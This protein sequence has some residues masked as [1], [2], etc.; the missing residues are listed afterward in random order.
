[1][2]RPGPRRE[3]R[4]LGKQSPR[5]R[6]FLNP[7]THA[8]FTTCPQCGA[9]MRL[10][11]LPLVIH[12]D[13]Q[14]LVAL[15]KACRYCPGCDLLIAHQDEIERLLAGFLHDARPEIVG[16]RYLVVGTGDR[17]AWRRGMRTPLRIAEAPD[18]VHD[19]VDVVRFEPARPSW[20]RT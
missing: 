14:Q 10:R 15:N 12:I 17:P 4:L 6:F 8:R 9:R 13:P 7:Y 16:N 18:H 1:M 11:K 3:P 5:Y 2:A 19:F 20:G